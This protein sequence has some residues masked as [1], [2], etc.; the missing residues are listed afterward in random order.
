[1]DIITASTE[2]QE[3]RGATLLLVLWSSLLI[4]AILAGAFLMARGEATS[5]RGQWLD[6]KVRASALSGLEIAAYQLA[7]EGEDALPS[8]YGAPIVLNG[9]TATLAP[10]EQNRQFDVNLATETQWS[11]FLLANGLEKDTADALAARVLDW[12][13]PDDLE[14]PNGA[15]R[16]AYARVNQSV[17][18]G[19]RPFQTTNEV[20]NV[21]DFPSSLFDCVASQLTV[22]GLS[23]PDPEVLGLETSNVASQRLSTS[24][25]RTT[26]GRRYALNVSVD[27]GDGLP[28]SLNA[29]LRVT[30]GSDKPYEYLAVYRPMNLP[31]NDDMRCGSGNRN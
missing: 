4:S 27:R 19:N 17:Q 15:E 26:P 20:K 30:G 2:R 9:V 1:M 13:D 21:L 12:R 6:F 8:I 10:G 11:S 16:R 24:S 18:I 14:R 23:R 5:V 28:Y 25:R 7:M 3:Q 29:V 31:D 22:I